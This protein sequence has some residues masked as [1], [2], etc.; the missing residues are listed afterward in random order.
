MDRDH[1]GGGEQLLVADDSAL[2]HSVVVQHLG[3][4]IANKTI[5]IAQLRAK[6]AL[7]LQAWEGIHIDPESMPPQ[8]REVLGRFLTAMDAL[9]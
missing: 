1:S 8:D 7:L 4:E 6:V 9:R 3:I 2:H 5:E